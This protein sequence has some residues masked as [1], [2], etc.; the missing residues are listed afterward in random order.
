MRFDVITLFPELFEAPLKHG[1][2]RRAWDSG[3]MRLHLWQLRDYAEDA[4][5]RVDDRPY[6]GGPGMVM[7]AEPLERALAALRADRGSP[8][9]VVHFT[10][11]GR[12]IDQAL[13]QEFAAG[14]GAILLC[15]RYEGIDQ[16]VLAAIT[17]EINESNREV[18]QKNNEAARSGAEAARSGAEARRDMVRGQPV[19]AA[20]DRRDARDDRRDARDDRR[21]VA[22]EAGENNR[23][24]A[25]HAEYNGLMG[26]LEPPAVA[27]KRQILVDL[28][29]LA[30]RE[31]NQNRKEIQEDRREKR[32][33]VRERRE[34]RRQGP[35]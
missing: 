16:R 27:R 8:A 32:E 30:Q 9:P 31:I 15:G 35:R 7:L 14:T 25:M 13:I 11:T 6:G 21:D 4:Y 22:R 3:A 23:L 2:T 5:R 28:N 34:D 29:V 18:A 19:R 33:D 20:D 17:G 10:P 24:R 1:I 12:R 26:R